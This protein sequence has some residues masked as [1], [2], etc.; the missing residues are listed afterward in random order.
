[1]GQTLNKQQVEKYKS[2][3]V[4]LEQ[5]QSF[6]KKIKTQED[7][8]EAIK[9]YLAIM[10]V[11]EKVGQLFQL[12]CGDETIPQSVIQTIIDGGVGSFINIWKIEN[13]N[14]VQKIAMEQS[15]L[16]I[17]LIIGRDVIHG[18]RTIFPI[19]LAQA[20]SFNPDLVENGCRISAI[21]CSAIGIKWTFSPMVDIA[22]DP[23]WG[24]IA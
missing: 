9:K 23:R 22:R 14:Q 3:R 18:Y 6:V 24:R 1:M 10:T 13:A 2:E 5:L 7:I 12:T 19:P 8:E 20:A 16:K 21:E 4:D 15:R 11:K 17:P